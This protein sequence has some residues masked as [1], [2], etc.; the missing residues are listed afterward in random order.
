[1]ASS[2]LSVAYDEVWAVL[3][4]LYGGARYG[5]KVRLPHSVVMTLLFGQDLSTRD[6]LKRILRLVSEHATNLAV[7]ATV[8]KSLLGFLKVSTRHFESNRS[9]ASLSGRPERPYHS[10]VAGAI[11]GYFVWGRYSSLNYQ[12]LLYLSSRVLVA[13]GKHMYRATGQQPHPELFRRLSAIIWGAVMILF[14]K[15]PELLHPSL[16]SSMDEIYRRPPCSK[17]SGSD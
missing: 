9:E 13:A 15:Y 2:L 1:M 8:Y 14:E 7:F 4:A 10:F 3:A 12:I 16:K 6:K 11:G 17:E 5:V